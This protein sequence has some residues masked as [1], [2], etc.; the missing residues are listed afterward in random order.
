MCGTGGGVVAG[1]SDDGLPLATPTSRTLRGC[2]GSMDRMTLGSDRQD[3][4]RDRAARLNARGKPPKLLFSRMGERGAAVLGA[5]STLGHLR[6]ETR[7]TSNNVGNLVHLEAPA[8]L[9]HYDR[10]TAP[11]RFRTSDAA[12]YEATDRY[13]DGIVLGYAN[14][15]RP[16]NY[17]SEE[18]REAG[19][20][21]LLRTSE[22]LA[23]T[24][25]PIYVMGVGL[26][27]PLAPTP[28]AI[29]P[30]LFELLRV[31]NDRATLFAVRGLE[32]EAWLH[33]V[34]LTNAVALGCPSLFAFPRSVMQVQAP[35]T[36]AGLQIATAGRIRAGTEPGR[37]EAIVRIGEA[38]RASYVFQHDFFT[39][40]RKT[41]DEQ[42]LYNDATSEIDAA[43]VRARGK[44]IRYD[45]PFHDYWM[46]RSTE[47]WR[48]FAIGKDAYVGDRF[49]GGV[50]FFQAGRPAL[51][52]KNDLR[53]DELT[54]FHAL[55]T[56]SSRELLD[57]DPIDVVADRLSPARI[58][59]FK[60]NYI[61]RYAAFREALLAKGLEFYDDVTADDLV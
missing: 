38:F 26:Q 16:S 43:I 18:E 19:T 9:L 17:R 49:H 36:I 4:R 37:L 50:V 21:S 39:L 15:I 24:K 41:G 33:S 3:A 20:V 34:G 14:M 23:Q 54:H 11:P 12:T 45:L 32:T 2:R 57:E 61:R 10:W 35:T 58:T 52:V 29:D 60:E 25:C 51:I 22:W 47:K 6:A 42:I 55:P 27:E 44:E 30:R 31:I 59:A 13:Y 28:D 56:A 40:F 46:F 7:A 48:G 1:C 8:K 53:V 5:A